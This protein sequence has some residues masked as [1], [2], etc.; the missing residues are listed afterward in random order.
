MPEK[1]ASEARSQ[2]PQFRCFLPDGRVLAAKLACKG[3]MNPSQ[4]I[5]W[6]EQSPQ[7]RR[8]IQ[9]LEAPPL[10]GE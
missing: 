8:L 3:L 7:A 1:V 9:N 10:A 4:T 2:S 5:D 6:L